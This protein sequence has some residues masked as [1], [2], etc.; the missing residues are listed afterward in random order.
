MK[1]ITIIGTGAYGTALANVLSENGHNIKMIGVEKNQVDD[2]NLNHRNTAF[3]PTHK[4]NPKIRAYTDWVIGME[5]CEII[6]ICVPSQYLVSICEN[7]NKYCKNKVGIVNATKGF[8]VKTGDLPNVI[9]NEKIFSKNIAF[10]GGIYGPSIASEV[11]DKKN[12]HIAAAGIN[13]YAAKQIKKIFNNSYFKVFESTDINVIEYSC[14][15]KNPLA[16]MSG[17]VYAVF[18]SMST[19][20]SLIAIGI[21][22]IKKIIMIATKKS[23]KDINMNIPSLADIILT[24]TSEKSRNFQLG[25]KIGKANNASK[26]LRESNA[27]TVEGL[28]TCKIIYELIGTNNDDLLVINSLYDIIYNNK[29]PSTYL[30]FLLDND[31][32]LFNNLKK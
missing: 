19:T 15:L 17:M 11:L 31:Q 26:V 12:I 1:N 32:D 9:L 20:A 25:F 14:I 10:L 22:E 5:N 4:I 21:N 24:T 27:N 8:D 3:F 13:L 2:I 7:I 28:V 6:V 23:F 16:I 29:K 30:Q 18:G